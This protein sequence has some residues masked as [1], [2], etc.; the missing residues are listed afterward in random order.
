MKIQNIGGLQEIISNYEG[1]ILDAWGVLHNGHQPFP[2]VIDTLKELRV[3]GIKI[4]VLSN[5]P[6]RIHN[7][8][9]R[10]KQ[11]GIERNLYDLL[12]SS[13]EELH[14]TMKHKNGWGNNFYHLGEVIHRH[15][16]DDL[17]INRQESLNDADFIINTGMAQQ[18]CKATDFDDLFKEAAEKELLMLCANPDKIVMVGDQTMLCAGSFALRY[19]ELGGKTH[20]FGK[21]YEGVYK[22]V[23]ALMDITNKEKVI[24]VGDSFAT[25]IK[26]ANNFG[27]DSIIVE[28]GIHGADFDLDKLSKTYDARPSFVMTELK[29]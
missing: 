23:L 8:E 24:A 4:L 20:Y 5:A 18:D 14:L 6:R 29:Y 17:S 19:E 11:V 25:D 1:I 9:E 26:G 16:F 2:H 21:P 13:G 10:T 3:N 7:I 22:T 28:T 15:L 12:H 27:I